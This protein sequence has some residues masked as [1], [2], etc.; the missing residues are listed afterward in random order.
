MSEVITYVPLLALAFG[1]TFVVHYLALSVFPR[2]GLLDFPERYG[3][4]RKRLPYPTG[5]L[6]VGI[7]LVFFGLMT[8]LGMQQIGVIVS[9]LLLAITSFLDDRTPLP[10]WLRIV[11]QLIVCILLFATGSRIYTITNPFDIFGDSIV[12][13][14][15][16]TWS[17]PVFGSLPLM[18]G[19]FTVIWLGLTMNALNWFDGIPGQ[20]SSLSTIG[21][22]MLG[23]LAFSARVGQPE[24]GALALILCAISGACFLFD[25]PPPRVLMGDSGSMFFGLM[26]GLLGIYQGGKVATAF[27]VLGVPLIDAFLVTLRRLL[28]GAS[29]LKGGQDHLHHRLRAR[30]IGDLPIVILT[31]CIGTGFGISALFLSTRGKGIAVIVLIGLMLLLTWWSRPRR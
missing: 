3:L 2:L 14:D 1:V 7:F 6:A 21:F 26:L 30:G 16:L 9:V 10:S 8:D 18:S 27:L 29:P 19:I 24:L 4:S 17:V 11:I 20:V 12:K 22:L 13:L 28:H 23:L 25:V 15:A 31:A 5:I